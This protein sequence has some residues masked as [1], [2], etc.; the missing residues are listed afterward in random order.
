MDI[1]TY[2]YI[3]IYI[4]REREN[5]IC[6]YIYIFLFVYRTAMRLPEAAARPTWSPLLPGSF[7]GPLDSDAESG[8]EGAAA[9]GGERRKRRR[10]LWRTLAALGSFCS[11]F[12][13]VVVLG[14]P[15]RRRGVAART[16]ELALTVGLSGSQPETLLDK[17]KKLKAHDPP[18]KLKFGKEKLV[19]DAKG[20]A[21]IKVLI[22]D[23]R[24]LAPPV[25]QDR[26]KPWQLGPE[27]VTGR[28]LRVCTKNE[29]DDI[30]TLLDISSILNII[31]NNGTSIT[32]ILDTRYTKSEVDKSEVP[33]GQQVLERRGPGPA[34]A[35]GRGPE[36]L[37][38]RP[39]L[40]YMYIYIYIY[41]YI[42]TYIY[43]YIYTHTHMYVH[44]CIHMYIYIERER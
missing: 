4:H 44:I 16:R 21:E 29:I 15:L 27:T 11:A 2:V 23:L 30:I 18:W 6:I 39:C 14:S 12:L 36:H 38:G 19:E 5:M 9:K 1:Y 28:Y 40:P 22:K 20:G 8:L 32:H 26:L 10:G 24:H 42:H 17:L 43:I 37:R 13:L 35:R 31:N 7:G 41:I 3:Y 33:E 34:Q 25:V